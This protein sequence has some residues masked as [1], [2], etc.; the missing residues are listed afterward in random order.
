MI[1]GTEEM[2]EIRSETQAETTL[3]I[4]RRNG[5]QQEKASNRSKAASTG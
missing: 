5:E 4:Q 1:V 2:V 3:C